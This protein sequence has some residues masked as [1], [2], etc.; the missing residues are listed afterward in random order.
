MGV[1]RESQGGYLCALRT[2]IVLDPYR[3]E[4]FTPVQN[5]IEFRMWETKKQS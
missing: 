1:S 2:Q 4:E 5:W 3:S